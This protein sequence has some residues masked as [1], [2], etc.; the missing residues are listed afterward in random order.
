[1]KGNTMRKT[2]VSA[3][4]A[5]ACLTCAACKAD[6]DSDTSTS[7]STS[8][9]ESLDAIV[10]TKYS[11][12]TDT[13]TA[14]SQ[15]TWGAWN[16]HDPK[17]FQ[18]T[19]GTYYVYSTDASCGNEG[20]AGLQIRTSSDLVNWTCLSKSALG[21]YWDSDMLT[22]CGMT[23]NTSA[24]TKQ[25][26]SSYTAVSWAPTVI[27]QNGLYYMYHGV[28]TE[29]CSSAGEAQTSWLGLAIATSAQGPFYPADSA[30]ADSTAI[31]SELSTLGVSYSQSALVRFATLGTS[32]AHS[33]TENTRYYDVESMAT[34]TTKANSHGFGAI[35]PEFVY[36][37]ATGSLMTYTVGTNTCYAMTFGSWSGGIG[38][39]YV[40]AVSL[41]PVYY[42]GTT[43]EGTEYDHPIDYM[44]SGSSAGDTY[45][46]K[47]F[48][49]KLVGGCG[50]GYEGSQLIYNSSTGYYYAFVSM[51][52]LQYEYRIGVARCST[53]DGDYTSPR[54]V[55][56]M[57][58]TTTA[59][60]K[61]HARGGKIAGAN[62]LSGEYS[63]R[64]PGGQSILRTSDGKI[65]MAFHTRTN[66]RYGYYFY[67][68]I[69]QMFFE[70]NGWPVL[71]GN[72][73]YDDYDGSDEKLAA[74][75]LSDI[76]GTY[77]TIITALGTSTSTISVYGAPSIGKY[78][79]GD[80][81][82]TA[83]LS[84]T[85]DS[86]GTI[87][88]ANYGGTVTLGSDGYSVTIALTDAG[89]NTL[90]TFTGYALKAT[91][92]AR[93]GSVT[94]KTITFTTVC[95]TANGKSTDA[96]QYFWGNKHNY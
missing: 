90:G 64:C 54:S 70:T 10:S 6:A 20:Y 40:D 92:W 67:L 62:E 75:T 17:L 1:M 36:D 42:P 69:H 29:L 33:D 91:D 96:G 4:A 51:G 53:I 18:D 35:D 41:K 49:H 59:A 80:A 13:A 84:M 82:P 77:D 50:A 2:A 3:L 48:V 86:S 37:V 24:E 8:T 74:L 46:L 71:N 34:T 26:N 93:K 22:W 7:T 60:A 65:M 16:V 45:G 72:E 44:P 79:T 78:N 38:L 15:S 83:S 94:R 55:S 85:I 28:N 68:Q 81:T 66:F 88:G 11:T 76:A 27:K 12:A 21:T 57:F 89:G 30:A 56:V 52:D 95:V 19:D 32:T 73:Y 14:T 9:S 63:W 5:L 47:N 23:A 39:V 31:A 58:S 61:Y 25:N 43:N 87:S